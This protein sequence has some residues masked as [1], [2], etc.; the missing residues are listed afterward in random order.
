MVLTWFNRKPLKTEIAYD[1][2]SGARS[3]GNYLNFFVTY[4]DNLLSEM[5]TAHL[6]SLLIY[7]CH[8]FRLCTMDPPD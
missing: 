2:N 1:E 5:L 8:L 7:N 4:I 6:L 3:L